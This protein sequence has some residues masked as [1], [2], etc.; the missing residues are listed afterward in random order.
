M[1]SKKWKSPPKPPNS[2]S[3]MQP[4]HFSRNETSFKAGKNDTHNS[5][6]ALFLVYVVYRMIC[7]DILYISHFAEVQCD[8][9]K[10]LGVHTEIAHKIQSTKITSA[11]LLRISN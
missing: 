4:P 8:I 3:I 7:R 2:T 9:L 10:I 11:S 5:F 6:C 1:P